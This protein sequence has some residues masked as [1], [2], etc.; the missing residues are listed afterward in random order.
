MSNIKFHV[1][2]AIIINIIFMIIVFSTDNPLLVFAVLFWTLI[3]LLKYGG[4]KDIKRGLKVFIPLAIVTAFIN[5]CFVSGGEI[6]IFR[7]LNKSFTLETIV[8]ALVST[9]KLIV[10]IDLFYLLSYMIDS[11]K[12]LS[13]FSSKM[14][15]VTLTMLISLKLVPNM[16][17]RLMAIKEVYE[18]RGV[19]YSKTTMKDKIKSYF[20]VLSILL[21]DSLEC[22]FDIGESAYVRGFLSGKRSEYEKS[23]LKFQDKI[24]LILS[25][26]I[27]IVHI[28]FLIN[29][30][31]E[32]DVY[33]V[34]S[35]LD[36]IN[37]YSILEMGIIVFIT[38]L[39]LVFLRER[40]K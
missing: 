25:I 40:N 10:V 13:Y 23:Y 33:K 7:F 34:N 18:V 6:V 22:S 28:I 2:P 35:L 31:T 26:L 4:R 30:Y 8:Y 16:K 38:F 37:I 15:K 39:I 1:L 29:G 27:F 17:K 36:F 12:S 32:Y 5:L 14:P 19:D 20:P 9:L 21:E 24:L 3:L 11:D